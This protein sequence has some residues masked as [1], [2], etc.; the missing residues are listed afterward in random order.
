MERHKP[1]ARQEKPKKKKVS[2]LGFAGL[3]L[4]RR[5]SDLVE[6]AVQLANYCINLLGQVA[7]I[8]RDKSAVAQRQ[9]DEQ[10]RGLCDDSVARCF[11][12]EATT[13]LAMLQAFDV[14]ASQRGSAEFEPGA[15][16]I[17]QHNDVQLGLQLGVVRC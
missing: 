14:S 5:N 15:G 3:A 11:A 17:I 16:C 8:H 10:T 1:C 4:L 9:H 12:C 6:Q 13:T 7:G 2:C